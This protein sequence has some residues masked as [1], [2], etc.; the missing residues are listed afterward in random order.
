MLARLFEVAV[1]NVR[2]YHFTRQQ[3]RILRSQR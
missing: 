3:L 1:A 2:H